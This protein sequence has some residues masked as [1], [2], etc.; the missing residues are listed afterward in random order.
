MNNTEAGALGGGLIGG[1]LGTIVGAACH[2]PLAGAAVGA[3]AGAGVGALAGHS[4]DVHEQKVQNAVAANQAAANQAAA[5]AA[6]KAPGYEQIVQM[7]RSGVP[8]AVI[9]AQ[10][11]NSGAIYQPSTNDILYL[12][13]GGVSQAV[14]QAVQDCNQPRVVPVGT[15]VYPYPRD[16][17]YDSPG[18]VVYVGGGYY[19]RHW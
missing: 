8:D 3:A 14:I 4:E 9:I 17:Y 19:H 5:D 1:A 15:V 11:R 2:A 10:V 12:Q 16:Y 6:A 18:G 13:Q 7:S